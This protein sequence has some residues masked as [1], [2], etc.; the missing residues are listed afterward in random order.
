[1]VRC[2]GKKGKRQEP[3]LRV[4]LCVNLILC[5]CN[6]QDSSSSG[7]CFSGEDTKAQTVGGTVVERQNSRTCPGSK[8][9]IALLARPLPRHQGALSN[10]LS[11]H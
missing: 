6:P 7:C 1:M 3:L 5:S 11:R 9:T 4:N 10:T 2:N 8:S